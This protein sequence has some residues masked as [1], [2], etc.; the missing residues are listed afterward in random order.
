VIDR[1]HW[2]ATGGERTVQAL[3][4]GGGPGDRDVLEE[5]FAV[6][7][8]A[9]VLGQCVCSEEAIR[10]I[11]M[12]RPDVVL[13]DLE[14]AEAEGLGVVRAI[15]RD[16]MPPLVAMAADARFALRAIE[17]EAV[18]YLVKPFTRWRLGEAL[19]RVRQ[20]LSRVA[21]GT[22]ML[23]A[24]A[25][26]PTY[27]TRIRI[28][29]REHIRFVAVD[30]VDYFKAD[31]NYVQLHIGHERHRVRRRLKD[32]HGLLDP[33]R[34]VRIHRSTIVNLERVKEV[35]PWFNGDYV[36]LLLGGGQLRVS[37]FYRNDLLRPQF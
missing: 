20:R 31:G 23:P 25:P 12:E 30:G 1:A 18:D 24:A 11:V 9:R 27:A 2:D 17:M 3:I 15:G 16:R 7:A 36:A 10:L 26:S 32:I 8:N 14:S 29:A 21:C 34:F 37:R 4:V 13:L 6:Q 22:V 35:Q 33:R 28:K 19:Q 5:A